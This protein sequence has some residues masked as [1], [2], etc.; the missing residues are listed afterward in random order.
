MKTTNTGTRHV[1]ITA[2]TAR[3]RLTP[4]QRS[5]LIIIEDVSLRFAA[6]EVLRLSRLPEMQDDGYARSYCTDFQ[7]LCERRYR[8]IRR[9]W[10]EDRA[11]GYEDRL[12]ETVEACRPE[13]KRLLAEMRT[14]LVQKVPYKEVERCIA[15]A[16]ASG[17]L[18]SCAR[19]HEWLTGRK[20]YYADH[21]RCLD[22][23][24]RK[25]E[26]PLLNDGKLHD[27]TGSKEAFTK[28]FQ[29]VCDRTIDKFTTKTEKQGK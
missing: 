27:M 29:A 12:Q 13:Y 2:G 18:Y 4:D 8:Q 20:Q 22:I 3:T 23:I 25:F 24:Y 11:D 15:V 1:G 5:M 14:A 26:V 28:M 7:D 10:G 21:F 17:M 19:S 6:M 9:S 16:V